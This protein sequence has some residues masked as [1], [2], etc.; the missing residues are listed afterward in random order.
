M[1]SSPV[2]APSVA[3]IVRGHEDL[4]I[5]FRR[6]V[7]AHPELSYEEYRT[8]DQIVAILE[9]HG[10]KP[11][12]LEGTGAYVDVG[13]GP[14]MMG[15][16][17]DI[18]A[19]PVMEETG[20]EYA[21]TNPGVMHAC[22]HDIHTTVMIGV[23]LTLHEILS[24]PDAPH[25]SVRV[26]FQPAEEKI[27]GGAKRVIA[28]GVLEPV[29]RIVAL[30]CEPRFD[31]GTIATRIGPITSATD[32]IRVHL[33]GRGGHSSRPHLTEDVVFALSQIA[34]NVPAVLNRRIDARSVVSVVWGHVHA[35]HA[36]NAIPAHGTLAGTM[37]CLDAEAW[38]DAGA[39]LDEV[40]QQVAAPYR[41]QVEVEHIR[42]VPPVVNAEPETALLE[43]AAR[44][45]LGAKAIQLAPQ[46]MGGEDFAWM[47]QVVPGSMF[48]LG[49]RKVGG[50]DYDLHM[51]NYDPDERAIGIGVRV[52][53][54][55][56]LRALQGLG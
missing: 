20:L 12:R 39:L 13:S 50:P 45:E 21:S 19:L 4:L 17:G 3:E 28:Q 32:T 52:M 16:R 42:G 51:G 38:D 26:I 11:V 15:F 30:H 2:V 8:T 1:S 22:G 14:I 24:A 49:T 9:E 55:A 35:G 36:P 23:A 33:T 18:D 6:D 40:I 37:R 54:T 46:S 44:I 56:G 47:T 27:P 29:P 7:H 53:A 5:D 48:R 43:D 31:V 10:L 34:V 41:V 25:G